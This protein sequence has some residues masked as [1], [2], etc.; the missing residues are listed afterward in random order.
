MAF[1]SNAAFGVFKSEVCVLSF[2]RRFRIFVRYL[3]ANCSKA[4][5]NVFSTLAVCSHETFL[6]DLIDDCVAEHYSS[7]VTDPG[8]ELTI[9]FIW[10]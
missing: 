10:T 5:Y 9:C 6:Q 4:V 7:K 8:I 2:P 3:I 1:T